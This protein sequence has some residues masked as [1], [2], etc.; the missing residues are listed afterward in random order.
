M[1]RYPGGERS[2]TKE[3]GKA[4]DA[5]PLT[6]ESRQKP[7]PHR[8]ESRLQTGGGEAGQESSAWNCLLASPRRRAGWK[9]RSCGKSRE[10]SWVE[11][12]GPAPA[13]Y[14]IRFVGV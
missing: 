3:R 4:I 7:H 6:Y 5:V 9:G 13:R 2:I 12:V 8:R 10:E 1:P 14:Q 11:P